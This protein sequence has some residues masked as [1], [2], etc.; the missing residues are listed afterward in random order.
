LPHPDHHEFDAAV[1]AQYQGA[2]GAPREALL[3]FT[4]PDADALLVAAW[5][6]EVVDARGIRL[7]TIYGETTLQR[8]SGAQTVAWDGKDASGRPAAEGFYQL[9]L[10]ALPVPL[11]D[12]LARSGT[13]AAARVEQFLKQGGEQA[14]ETVDLR[15]GTPAAPKLLPFQALP[16]GGRSA[17]VRSIRGGLRSSAMV[18]TT[19][20]FPYS[21]YYGNLHSQTNHSDGGGAVS[22]CTSSENP[23]A[24]AFGP[25]DAWEM[26]RTQA[27]GDILLTS[28]HNH[29][30]DGSTGTNGAADPAHSH[31]LFNGGLQAAIDYTA[32]HP[33]FLALYGTEWGVISG[34]GHLNVLNPDGLASWESS[35]SGVLFGDVFVQKSDYAAMYATMRAR[36]WVGMFNHPNSFPTTVQFTVNGTS[37]GYDPNGDEVMAL[38]EV[39]NTS[40]FSHNTTETETF[41]TSYEEAWKRALEA[42]YH[43]A[44]ASDQDNHCANWGLSYTN[45]TGVLIPQG[46]PLTRDSFIAAVRARHVF[47]TMDKRSQIVLATGSG[48]LMGDRIVNAGPLTL[49][50]LFATTGAHTASRIQIF[51]GVPGRNGTVT[52]PFEGQASVSLTPS[53]G[54]HFYFA[55]VTQDNGDK[56]WS[57]PIWVDQ[58]AGAVAAAIVTPATDQTVAT[59][60][61]VSFTATATTRNSAIVSTAWDFGDGASDSG[62]TATHT[63]ANPGGTP[64]TYLA[65]F[66][67]TDD[68]G[69]V[70]AATRSITVLPDPALNTPPTISAISTVTIVKNGNATVSFTVDDAQTAPSLLTV[71]AA[72]SNAQLFPAGSLVPGGSAKSRTLTL[73][74]ALNQTGT[75]NITVTVLDSGGATASSAFAATVVSGQSQLI[76]SQYYEGTSNNKWLEITNVGQGDYLPASGQLFLGSWFNPATGGTT[77]SVTPIGVS[78]PPG[79]SVLFRNS[80]AVLPAA[81]NVTGTGTPL[82]GQSPLQFNGD[83]ITYLTPVGTNNV[84]S[85]NAR[86]DSIGLNVA[87]WTAGGGNGAAGGMDRSYVRNA[88]VVSPAADYLASQWTIKTLA[89][90]NAALTG[91]TERLGEHIYNHAPSIS[92][93]AD[94]SIFTGQSVGPLTFTVGDA[95]TSPGALVVTAASD[96][97]ALLPDSA[98]LLD[99]TGATRTL[100]ATPVADQTGAALVTLTVTDAGGRSS[101]TT[102]L[103]TV[104]P[105]VVTGLTL[106]PTSVYL[107]LGAQQQF[108]AQVTGLGNVSN[109]VRWSATGGSIDANGLYT[110]PL[111]GGPYFVS[112]E[113]VQDP[114]FSATAEVTTNRA[115]VASDASVE[116]DEDTAVAVTLS[117]SDPDADPLTFTI[118][119]LPAHG[120]LSGT[121]PAL[122]YQPDPDYNGPDAFTFTATD[123]LSA[124]VTG[125]VSLTVHPVNDAPVA[126]DFQVHTDEDVPVAVHLIA[127]DVEQDALS[128]RVVRQPAHG[129]ITD[130]GQDRVY[131]PAPDFNGTDSFTF[132]AGDG[133]LTSREATVTVVVAPVNDAPVAQGQSVRTLEDTPVSIT[134]QATDVDGDALGFTVTSGPAHGRLSEGGAIRTYTPDPDFNGADQFTFVAGDGRLSSQPQV[135]AI[136][137]DP[138][139]DAPVAANQQLTTAEDTPLDVL[140]TASDVDHDALSF[141]IVAPPLHGRLLGAPPQL[142]YVPDANW[143][144]TDA[145]GF[146]A[147]DGHLDSRVATVQITVTAVND[148]PVAALQALRTHVGQPLLIRLTATDVE[149]DPLAFRVVSQPSHGLLI[150]W[151]ALRLYLPRPG[152]HGQDSF[153][154]V[155]NDGMLDSAPAKVVIDVARGKPEDLWVFDW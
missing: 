93:L 128:F 104:N 63:Y 130:G 140:L 105:S 98:I 106:S 53:S 134:L 85:Y 39:T 69:S 122:S 141:T 2:A 91:T 19:G 96:N 57:A 152:F 41:S 26:M 94:V 120:T 132:V 43:L 124:A 131:I 70:G 56:L 67:A 155:A 97:G 142:K 150:G 6:V 86:L 87:S 55:I 81:A 30:Y 78:I 24:G 8:G 47:A 137:V 33:G 108:T 88:N 64:V 90:V 44:P 135:V 109:Q 136:T 50:V 1:H 3:Q 114:S 61:A 23:W 45:R 82:A 84:A 42:G 111:S 151:G 73:T 58:N 95:E 65:T 79:G 143:N 32:A 21:I 71:S 54:K 144:G 16:Q 148:R 107:H 66:S 35:S 77:F 76:I 11:Q 14:V 129:V 10:T 72:S 139:N 34:G 89:V 118:P 37:F 138:V 36:G 113:S 22:T 103:V 92:D 100:T 62:L 153:L 31:A 13:P 68:L 149:G 27:G 46:T 123:G 29:M 115:P 49:N 112:A 20:G 75:A 74:P 101:L 145:F 121:A 48:A 127:T 59:G 5:R 17:A 116:T 40:A 117:A 125:H 147:S 4:F 154:F 119:V 15:V 38:C 25:A 9:R 146:V 83:D 7:R 80:L 102:F 133:R 28:E 12:V 99:G 18:E 110:P 52:Q 60:T 51:E 126:S